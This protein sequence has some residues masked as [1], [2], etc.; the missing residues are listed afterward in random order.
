ML[1]DIPPCS[2]SHKHNNNK[3]NT[4]NAQE[5]VKE[6]QARGREEVVFIVHLK[7]TKMKINDGR[8]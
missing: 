4:T 3:G 1:L 6:Q 2:S 5:C 8:G 7:R